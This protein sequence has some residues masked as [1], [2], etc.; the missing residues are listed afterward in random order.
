MDVLSLVSA[1]L[2][3]CSDGHR[4]AHRPPTADPQPVAG[5]RRTGRRRYLTFRPSIGHPQEEMDQVMLTTLRRDVNRRDGQG[6]RQ[7]PP[8][9]R[10]P[11]AR[12]QGPGVVKM[13]RVG[14]DQGSAS[15]RAPHMMRSASCRPSVAGSACHPRDAQ[16]IGGGYEYEWEGVTHLA[17][18]TV[19]DGAPRTG[20]A[21]LLHT[22]GIPGKRYLDEMR[23]PV[24]TLGRR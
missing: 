2:L 7:R 8:G 14:A 24:R 6:R 13:L 18:A 20:R 4:R 22:D 9:S 3:A 11:P 21:N 5:R 12:A 16:A 17:R 1:S 15:W 10:P 23:M 19:Y